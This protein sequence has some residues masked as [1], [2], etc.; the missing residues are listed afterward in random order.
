MMTRKHFV[1]LAARLK[2]LKPESDHESP[3]YNLWADTVLEMAYFSS[4]QNSNFDRQR[5]LTACGLGE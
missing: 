2:G 1:D 3:E 4:T 5:F